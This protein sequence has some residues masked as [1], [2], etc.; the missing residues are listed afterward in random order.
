[1][2]ARSFLAA[3]LLA[4]SIPSA[5][6]DTQTPPPGALLCSGCHATNRTVETPVPRLVGRS[7]ADIK[8]AL[9]AFRTGQRAATVMDRIAKG[10]S[11]DEVKAIAEW[12]GV[13]KD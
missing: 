7:P 1:M 6:A 10:F 5:D 9:E 2:T 13:Q 4:A 12:Y 11:D 3:L 8:A